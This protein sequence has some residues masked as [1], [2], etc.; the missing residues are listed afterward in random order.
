MANYT[1][2]NLREVEDSAVK[3]GYAP[4]MS[5]RF[6][7]G[8]LGLQKSGVSLQALAPNKRGPFGHR[9]SEQEELYVVVAGGGRVKLDDEVVDLRQWD[10]LRVP[11][12]VTRQF[13]AGPDGIELIA[14]GAP[15]TG[16]SAG[17]DV[18]MLLGWWSD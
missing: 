5:A 15:R 18:E 10:A 14:Y 2:L 4:D 11:P 6:A 8:E 13:E 17:G 9:H 12:E 7:S 16:D 1:H 3:F